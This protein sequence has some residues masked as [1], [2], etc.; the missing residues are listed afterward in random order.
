MAATLTATPQ[1]NNTPPRVQLQISGMAGS[2]VTIVRTNADG[3]TALV[4]TANPGQVAT[5]A[6][7]DY[8]MPYTQAVSYTATSNT[9]DTATA[10]AASLYS[11]G[12]TKPWL[13]NVGVP[14]L[15]LPVTV[16]NVGDRT[17]AVNQGVHLV[18]GR[19]YPIV[20]TDGVRRAPTFDLTL[21]TVTATEY[22][23]MRQLV[24]TAT[25]LLLQIVYPNGPRPIYHYVAVGD[26][27]DSDMVNLS[28]TYVA[29]TL[30]CTVTASP[31]GL[32]QAQWT[33]SGVLATYSTSQQVKQ[34]YAT[35]TDLLINNPIAT[36]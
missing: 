22:K 16:A 9:G 33:C 32:L 11:L 23:A 19:E 24:G 15:S 35:C 36:P 12:V 5:A 20:R 14:G 30:P 21:R 26:V 18:L 2:T 29:W 27:T 8:E 4:R 28:S 7:F 10:T 1:P 3:T 13:V 6:W 17:R 31:A 34:R 25:T